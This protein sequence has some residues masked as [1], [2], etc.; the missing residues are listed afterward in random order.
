MLRAEFPEAGERSPDELLAAYE[1]ML[2]AAVE[3]VGVERVVEE[4]DLDETT[5]RRVADGDAADLPLEEAAAILGTGPEYPDADAVQAEAQDILLMGMT[6]AVMDVESLA[7]G[8]DDEM[9]PKE[10]QQKIEGRYPMTLAE[11]AVLHSYIEGEQR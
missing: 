4:T 8:I 3:S 11:Y 5:V 7:S 6:T 2:A 9:E 1:S 10:I